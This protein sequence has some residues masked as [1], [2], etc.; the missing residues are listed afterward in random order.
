MPNGIEFENVI[1]AALDRRYRHSRLSKILLF[2]PDLPE[3][4]RYGF[5][6]DHLLHAQ[7]GLVDRLFIV[8]CKSLPIQIQGDQWMVRYPDGWKDVKEQ[9]WS[10]SVSLLRHLAD[11]NS[12]RQVRIEACVVSDHPVAPIQPQPCK[13]KRITFHLFERERFF[14]WLETQKDL[15][16]RVEQ[17]LILSGLRHGLANPELGRPDIVS[18]I[19]FVSACRRTLDHELFRRFPF[20]EGMNWRSHAAINGTAGMGKSVMLAYSLFVL[21]CDYYVEADETDGT[22][23]LIPFAKEAG[24]LGFPPHA[25][26][27][28]TAFGL[29]QK[30][31]RV[32]EATWRHFV[33][34]FGA[35]ENS[36]LLHFHQPMFRL[37]DATIPDECNILVI[38][39]SHDLKPE[40]HRIVAGWKDEDSE[41]RYLLVACDRHQRLRLAGRNATIIHG[42]NFRNHTVRLRRNYRS[43]FPVFA[44]SLALM[45][46]W[47]AEDGPKIIPVNEELEGAFGFKIEAP[48]G[49]QITLSNINDSHPG[50]HWCYTVSRFVSPEDALCQIEILRRQDVLW[51][52]FGDEDPFFDYE[53]LSNFVYHPL[54]GVGAAAQIDKYIK[55]QEFSVV[56]IEGLPDAAFADLE[57]NPG[58]EPDE[59][60]MRMWQARRELYLCASRAN[61]F[62]LFVLKPGAQGEDEI[63]NMLSQLRMPTE[64]DRRLWR[65]RFGTGQ[66]TRRPGVIDHFDEE[67]SPAREEAPATGGIKL[68]LERPV[69]LRDLIASLQAARGLDARTAIDQVLEA[70]SDI[71]L[72]GFRMDVL[73]DDE[74]LRE[75][76]R[77]LSVVF[78]FR[79]ERNGFPAAPEPSNNG[80]VTQAERNARP[81]DL[82]VGVTVEQAATLLNVTMDR[83]LALLPVTYTASRSIETESDVLR[84]RSL[85]EP[86]PKVEAPTNAQQSPP[87]E[88]WGSDLAAQLGQRMQEWD[89]IRERKMVRRY[90]LLLSELLKR[91]PAA[92]EGLLRYQP[93]SRI[94]FSRSE[95]DI[96]A[97]H[98]YASVHR[99]GM[100]G[101]HAMCTLSNESKLHVLRDVLRVNGVSQ[102]DINRLLRAFSR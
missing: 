59:N 46:R 64:A 12:G 1:G 8:E 58:S 86:K 92:E 11:S 31:V 18:A 22:R 48:D 39:E 82:R 87:D 83:V 28:I 76:E 2:R 100:S 78:E 97:L 10:Q 62:L 50:N 101:L 6:I 38:D 41:K 20:S 35:L 99:L 60:E 55:G 27:S 54:Q 88:K 17:S 61:V 71:S 85:W 33:R 77:R 67:E 23:R 98:P 14:S 73:L 93:R 63:E 96:L 9:I 52:R 29:S 25:L 53:Q 102:A 66:P 30:Q 69:T 49:G 94:Y 84:L 75:F 37:W 81:V 26:R 44:G 56:V 42:L 80:V 74:R 32:L 91:K 70:A 34:L 21:S 79:E 47:F 68:L 13:D 5:E 19:T 45:F 57:A 90:V 36:H 24:E 51:V 40:A 16:Q 4:R 65:L 89:F 72:E 7:D 43:P 15:I 3:H 95:S